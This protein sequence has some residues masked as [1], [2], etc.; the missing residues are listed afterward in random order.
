MIGVG[1]AL[2]ILQ[3]TAH[4]RRIRTR[5]VVVAVH[6]AL[7]ALHRGVRSR[8]REPGGGMIEGRAR[9]G[10]GV[11]ALGARLREARLHVVRLRGALKVLQV[12]AHAGL[13]RAG[14]VVVAI[15]VTLRAL[16]RGVR[17]RQREAGRRVV[18]LRARPGRGVM[19]LRTRL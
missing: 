19:A 4:A 10:R 6:V 18:K 13:I 16:H 8:Q 12:S 9:P 5:E 15:H 11:V 1:G 17:P 14:L 2:E 7:R 3:V